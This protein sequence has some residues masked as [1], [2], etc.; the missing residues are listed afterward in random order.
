MSSAVCWIITWMVLLAIP[1][2]T[3]QL[4]LRAAI[5][6]TDAARLARGFAEDRP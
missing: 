3:V 6:T 5:E 1:V 4:W 2:S